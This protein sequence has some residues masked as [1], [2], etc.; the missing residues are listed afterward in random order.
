MILG[1]LRLFPDFQTYRGM[2]DGFVMQ[3][4]VCKARRRLR[5]SEPGPTFL[6]GHEGLKWRLLLSFYTLDQCSLSD[7]CVLGRIILSRSY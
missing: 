4:V 7:N 5:G 2:Q 6:V 3:G 1:R